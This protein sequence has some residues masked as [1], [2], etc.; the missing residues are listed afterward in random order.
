MTIADPYQTRPSLLRR[1]HS[2]DESG[3]LLFYLKYQPLIQWLASRRGLTHPNEVDLVIQAVMLHFSKLEWTHSPERGRFR[4]LVLR[5]TELKIHEVRRELRGL[6]TS[7]V[8]RLENLEAP[9]TEPPE[10]DR[11][12]RLAAAIAALGEDKGLADQHLQVLMRSLQGQTHAEISR[13]LKISLSNCMVIRH[14]MIK[15]LQTLLDSQP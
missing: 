1:I 14:R 2:R 10:D 8:A 4:N 3:W 13:D 15:R 6:P 7:E 11:E 12:S 9:P 5:V